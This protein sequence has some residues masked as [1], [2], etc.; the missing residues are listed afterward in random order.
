MATRLQVYND[1][2]MI[3]GEELLSALTDNRE[4]RRL[5]DQ[6]WDSGEVDSCLASGQWKFAMKTVLLDYDP[7]VTPSFGYRRAYAKPSDWVATAAVCSD[8]YF[9]SPLLQY[10]DEAGYWYC[11]LDQ[12]YVKY[13]SNDV[14]YGM[15]IASWPQKF[16]GYVSASFASK[17]ILRL[18]SDKNKLM[19][20]EKVLKKA[21]LEAKN[22]DAMSDPTKFPA[23]GSWTNSRLSRG[24]RRD[25]GNRGSLIG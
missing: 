23:S 15:N 5:L 11:D 19:V 13:I 16:Q 3:C 9:N 12:L 25:R 6:A 7:S 21:L 1:A 18:T 20:I 24:S 2:L 17:I 10:S 4:G 22:H 14:L 8:E